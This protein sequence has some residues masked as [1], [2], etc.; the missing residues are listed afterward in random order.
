MR[1]DKASA[2]AIMIS[3]SIA[4]S[5]SDPKL[6]GFI[7][8]N[9]SEINFK[10][11][12]SAIGWQA[13]IFKASGRFPLAR[14]L[15]NCLEKVTI[16]G[17]KLHY[18]LR[19]LKIEDILN[20]ADKDLNGYKQIVVIGA[21]GDSLGL[22]IAEKKPGVNVIEIDHPET[23]EIKQ[24]MLDIYSDRKIKNF[25]LLPV[26][27]S[28]KTLFSTL[29]E[30]DKFDFNEK[31]IFI[32]EGLFMYLPL[33]AVK[34]TLKIMNMF[35]KNYC[36]FIFTYMEANKEGK[37]SYLNQSKIVDFWLKYK[38]EPLIWGLSPDGVDKILKELGF[39]PGEHYDSN[40]L[41]KS[42]LNQ[43]FFKKYKIPHGENITYAVT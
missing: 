41:K 39:H 35:P 2:T 26:D 8:P 43:D 14:F 10:F 19:K 3:K 29:T 4:F 34:N 27:L 17:I 28:K 20:N 6:K 11:L 24:N 36:Q 38:K 40:K 37:P 31:T 22:R 7:D 1:V 25:Y 15:F 30:F 18:L 42:Y 13:N 16:P 32:A 5:S 23:Q 12:Y 9:V 21:G 33:E